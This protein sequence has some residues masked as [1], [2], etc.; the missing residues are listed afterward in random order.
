MNHNGS[1]EIENG[2]IFAVDGRGTT[3]TLN[4]IVTPRKADEIV[5]DIED[6]RSQGIILRV[7]NAIIVDTT[8]RD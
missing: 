5:I 3:K 4:V 6:L 1:I 7:N 2:E 8:R